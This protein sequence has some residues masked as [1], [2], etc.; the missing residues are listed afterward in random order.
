M[1]D[2]CIFC[3]IAS[4]KAKAF[5]VYEDKEVMAFFDINPASIG[6]TLIIPKKHYQDIYS[7]PEKD[8][9]KMMSVVKKLVLKYKEKLG[10]NECNILNANG[11]NAQQSVPHFHIHI[12]PR[13]ENDGLNMW[14][15]IKNEISANFDQLLK[16]LKD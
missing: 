7:I 3:K 12:V 15:E 13:F 11:K 6:H 1:T 4:G 5:T 2:N 16:K 14:Y 8:L 10:V 9:S